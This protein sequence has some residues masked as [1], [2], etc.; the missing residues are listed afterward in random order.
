MYRVVD[1]GR[2]AWCAGRQRASMPEEMVVVPIATVSR[3]V[4]FRRIG[5]DKHFV[6]ERREVVVEIC[7]VV[8]KC[9]Y[10]HCCKV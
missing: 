5:A 4:A 9:S 3:V 8:I 6:S 2:P 7:Y 10:S 1:I